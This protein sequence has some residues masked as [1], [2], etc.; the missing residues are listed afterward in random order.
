MLILVNGIT[1]IM[2]SILVLSNK[3][4]GYILGTIF[5]VTLMLWITIQFIIFPFEI[6]DLVFFILGF[7][8]MIFG[9]VALVSYCQE[10]FNFDESIYKNIKGDS[11]VLV[12]YF[13]RKK[14]TKK[15]AY[16]IANDMG[17]NILEIKTKEK[18]EGDLGFWWSGRFAMHRWRMEILPFELN[19]EDYEKVVIVTPIWVFRMCAPIRDFIFK[20]ENLL[21]DKQVDVIFNH[22]NPYLPKGAIKEIKNHIKVENIT[23][24]TTCLGHTFKHKH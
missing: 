4:I 18:T 3:K 13:S 2:A 14:Y 5:G 1:N 15:I 9:Y 10:Y 16:E 11:K 8:Q 20:Y 22:F 17:A 19:L 6:V 23:S 24:F 12:F 7:L 21:K